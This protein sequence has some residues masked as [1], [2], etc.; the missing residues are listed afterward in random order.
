MKVHG[1]DMKD[2]MLL[3]LAEAAFIGFIGGIVGL[4][5]SEI[6][7]FIINSL[8][9]SVDG[10]AT[11]KIS[12]IDWWLALAAVGFSTLMGM[13]AGYFPARRAMK[14]SPLAAIHTE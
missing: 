4:G 11:G 9:A 14:L 12:V 7:S 3:F 8:A 6:I 13:V 1:C 2:I 5:F 10:M